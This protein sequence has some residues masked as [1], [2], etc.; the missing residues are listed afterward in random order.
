MTFEE[1]CRAYQDRITAGPI[2]CEEY[3]RIMYVRKSGDYPPRGSAAWDRWATLLCRFHALFP[4]TLDREAWHE[5]GHIVVGHKLGWTVQR[6][7]RN[8]GGWPQAR[9][10]APCEDPELPGLHVGMMT[11]AGFVAEAM[12]RPEGEMTDPT[13]EIPEFAV[14]FRSADGDILSPEDRI[15]YTEEIPQAEVEDIIEENWTA[16][17]RVALL[18]LAGLP[19]EREALLEALEGVEQDDP[20]CRPQA[21]E[22]AVQRSSTGLSR[23]EQN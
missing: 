7:E 17:E 12:S 23:T 4:N 20:P 13:H 19:V 22:S 11:T 5:A 8:A 16:L 14:D 1:E 6:I 21:R 15:K 2:S 3:E 9:V 10:D 18:A